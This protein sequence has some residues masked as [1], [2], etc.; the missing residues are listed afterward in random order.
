MSQRFSSALVLVVA[1]VACLGGVV[2]AKEP[3]FKSAVIHVAIAV[4]ATDHKSQFV[5]DLKV[6]DFEVFEDGALQNIAD[7]KVVMVKALNS[8]RSRGGGT[9]D[10]IVAQAPL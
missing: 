3:R 5:D 7:F 6:D 1:T 8:T 10:M 2:V 4:V 9:G